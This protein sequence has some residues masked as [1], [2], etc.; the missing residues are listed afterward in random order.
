[1]GWMTAATTPMKPTVKTPQ[2]SQTVPG[3]SSSSVRMAT[4]F[5]IGGSVT[6]RMT[7]GTGLMRETVEIHIFFPPPLLGPLRV[8][9]ITTAAAVGPV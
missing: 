5:Q 1:M 8:H 4:A 6:G 2:N 3:T 9:L 7:A